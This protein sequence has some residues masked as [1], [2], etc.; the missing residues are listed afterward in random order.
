MNSSSQTASPW[1]VFATIGFSVIILMVFIGIQ[2]GIIVAL[3]YSSI[4]DLFDKNPDTTLL[5]N[6]INRLASNGDAISYALIPSAMAGALFVLL[7][8][9]IRKH[10]SI[11]EYLGLHIPTIKQVLLWIGVLVLFFAF[12]E[13][14]NVL[15][16]RPMPVWMIDTYKSAENRPLLWIT[17]VIAAPLFEELL[18]RG[19]MLEGLRHSKLGDL[20]AVIITSA[21]WASIHLQYEL[22]EVATIFIIGIIL[23]YAKIKTNSLYTVIILHALLNLISTIQVASL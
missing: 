11:K 13:A 7:F 18:F 6:E 19:F 3:A 17:L 1:G 20:G 10:I 21:V 12:M 5:V 2:T 8:T 4:S 22:F 23:G 16:D 15:I 9:K 14:L